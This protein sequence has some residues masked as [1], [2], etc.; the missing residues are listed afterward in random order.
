MKNDKL[1]LPPIDQVVP[2][3]KTPSDVAAEWD[4]IFERRFTAE[5]FG[6]LMAVADIDNGL[7]AGMDEAY[8]H[9][10]RL[11]YLRWERRNH[12]DDLGDIPPGVQN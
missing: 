1:R 7:D 5:Q 10:W 12:G 9:D 4:A 2:R 8:R 11:E 6:D 3:F